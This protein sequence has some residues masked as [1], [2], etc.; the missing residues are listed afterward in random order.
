MTQEPHCCE[1]RFQLRG[2]T[3]H[4]TNLFAW[5]EIS[6]TSNA[7]EAVTLSPPSDFTLDIFNFK[8]ALVTFAASVASLMIPYWTPPSTPAWFPVEEELF[9]AFEAEEFSF[10]LVDF[11]FLLKWKQKLTTIVIASF[12]LA[13]MI[14][15]LIFKQIFGFSS[16]DDWT[17]FSTV[18][19][20]SF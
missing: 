17:E 18:K 15:Y 7:L 10:S 13:I 6:D 8:G 4:P 19:T 3:K 12:N 14:Y 11:F 1:S 20:P 9:T 5:L 2:E 16:W